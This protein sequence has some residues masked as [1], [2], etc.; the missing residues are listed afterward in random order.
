MHEE[1][2]LQGL[3][4]RVHPSS[5]H[6]RTDR[7][8]Y[9]CTLRGRL[10]EHR[11]DALL[12]PVAV[13]DRVEITP[14]GEE[15]GAIE[16]IE[17]RRNRISRPAPGHARK[18]QIIAANVDTVV[19]VQSFRRPDYTPH[20]LDRTLA[21][22]EKFEIEH[23][24]VCMNKADLVEDVDAELEQ[25]APYPEIGYPRVVTS[26]REKTGISRLHEEL[27]GK[28]AVIVGPSGVGKSSLINALNPDLSLSTGDISERTEKGTH[29]TTTM[30][31]FPLDDG[32]YAI[33]TPGADFVSLWDVYYEQ[34][35]YY[36]PDIREV[37]R[38]CRFSNCLHLEE[39]G[40]AVREGIEQHRIHPHR[41]ESYRRII[42]SV[43]KDQT[44]TRDG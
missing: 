36:F 1:T 4:I 30:E 15:D 41:Y 11:D 31:L 17:E 28:I 10:K 27:I 8:I 14:E 13:G 43:K 42:E 16:N 25:M 37:A 20:V 38:D 24:V 21:A 39:P 32:T 40:C 26:T 5:F 34:V 23:A 2:T 19:S 12:R 35:P 22:A 3:V 9:T 33:D 6:V 18:E 29:R 7:G 44:H